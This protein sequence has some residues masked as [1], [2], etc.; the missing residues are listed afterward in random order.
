MKSVQL[1]LYFLIAIFSAFLNTSCGG[2]GGGGGGTV[3]IP[4]ATTEGFTATADNKIE[5]GQL[6][7]AFGQ[8]ATFD[9]DGITDETWSSISGIIDSQGK[10]VTPWDLSVITEDTVTMNSSLDVD[11]RTFSISPFPK[12]NGTYYKYINGNQNYFIPD[13][14]SNEAVGVATFQNGSTTSGEGNIKITNTSAS[15][16]K[17]EPLISSKMQALMEKD[18]RYRAPKRNNIGDPLKY[19][20]RK[21]ISSKLKKKSNRATDAIGTRDTF[22]HDEGPTAG[23]LTFEKIYSGSKCLIYSEVNT[24]TDTPYVSQTRGTVIGDAFEVENPFNDSPIFDVV[25]NLFGNP[26][27]INTAGEEIDEG[28]R[29]GEKQVIFLLYKSKKSGEG[30]FGY[31]Y[32][33][34]QEEKDFVDP[35][36]NYVSNGAEIV[37]LNQ[38][39]ASD[40]IAIMSTMAHEF[41]HLC[42]YNQKFVLN[43][44]FTDQI[45]EESFNE[46][47]PTLINEGQSVLSEDLN[48]FSLQMQGNKGNDFIF[49]SINSYVG[50]ISTFSPSFLSFS[51]GSGYGKG[52]LFWRFLYDSYGEAVVKTATHSPLIQPKNIESATG[53]KMDVLLQEFLLAI[54]QTETT[55]PINPKY[56]IS[57]IDRSVNY[58]DTKGNS[59]GKFEPVDYIDSFTNDE[60]KDLDPYVVRLYKILPENNAGSLDVS[61]TLENIKKLSSY[62]IFTAIIDK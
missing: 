4:P 18:H 1:F 35:N 47:V 60:I 55:R 51:S 21:N 43:G 41:Q 29:D 3:V 17:K 28:G 44:N 40:D 36:S 15:S 33:V 14:S 54:M 7:F 32:W 53:K 22:Y 37:Y 11:T 10:Y 25:T 61:F 42:D 38:I 39:F 56:K 27:G 2:G 26:W 46:E 52:Y 48:G 24:A 5:G 62:S 58:F 30:T 59:V 31:F 45:F 49:N 50:T 19:S 57:T 20:Q 12:N 6:E 9:G 8:T 23:H 13:L 16:A 34:D